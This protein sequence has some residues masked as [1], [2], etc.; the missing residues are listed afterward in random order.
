[1]LDNVSKYF[2]AIKYWSGL[3]LSAN[4]LITL[5]IASFSASASIIRAWAKPSALKISACLA[6]SALL[7]A[8]SFSPSAFKTAAFLIPSA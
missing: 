6:P 1:M 3:P 2:I 8:A 5:A 7:I 4:A